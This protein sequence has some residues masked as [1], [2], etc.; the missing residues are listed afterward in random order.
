MDR[1][2]IGVLSKALLRF[3][4]PLRPVHR[5]PAPYRDLTRRRCSGS[6]VSMHKEVTSAT[7][8][9]DDIDSVWAK[10]TGG[11][12]RDGKPIGFARY[13]RARSRQVHDRIF[14]GV[15]SVLKAELWRG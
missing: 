4:L 12:Q 6:Y 5:R 15:P 3:C 2:P 14:D 10:Y 11:E 1:V 9:K 13:V 7:T 8:A